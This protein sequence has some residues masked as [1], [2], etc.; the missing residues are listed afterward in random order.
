[1]GMQ[2]SS[3]GLGGCGIGPG[4][5]EGGG[6]SG[7][8]P[9]GP[10]LGGVGEPW[11]GPKRGEP[12]PG[13]R[14][15]PPDSARKGKADAGPRPTELLPPVGFSVRATGSVCPPTS[16]VN[17]GADKPLWAGLARRVH[18]GRLDGGWDGGHRCVTSRHSKGCAALEM[19]FPD[20]LSKA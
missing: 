16:M 20:G 5:I 18:C 3:S 19:I 9:S 12:V 17:T 6:T 8:G 15:P 14:P 10:G 2:L 1:M 4:S 7:A 13:M 11:R